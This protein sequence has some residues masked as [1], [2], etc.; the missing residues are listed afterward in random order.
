MGQVVNLRDKLRAKTVGAKKQFR[1]E[2]VTIGGEAFEVR[3]PS[4]AERARILKQAKVQTGDADRMDMAEL[5]IWAAILLTYVP[6]TEDHVF[7]DADYAALAA[8]PA[9][10]FVDEISRVAMRLMNAGGDEAKNSEETAND[11]SSSE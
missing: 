9:N 1:T 7:E 11:N 4:V 3:Q 8:Q 5:Q 10:G 6:G 2:T